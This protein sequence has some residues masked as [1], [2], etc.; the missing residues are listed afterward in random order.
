LS[1]GRDGEAPLHVASRRWDVPMAELLVRH[2]ANL[3]RR[4]ADGRTP[5]AV[6]ALSGNHLVADWLAAHGAQEV[7]SPLA[8][9]V[10]A[11]A[12]GDR[13]TA[14]SM[15]RERPSLRGDLGHEHHLLLHRAAERGDAAALETMLSCGFDPQVK[16]PENVTPLHRAAMGGHADSVRV[17]LAH[18]ADVN[19]RDGMFAASPL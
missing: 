2:G 5:F 4:R 1:W 19:A 16:D 9:F 12:R 3:Q 7:L 17:L 14:G 11:C 18:G 10:A 8:E 6:A 13:E 15:L